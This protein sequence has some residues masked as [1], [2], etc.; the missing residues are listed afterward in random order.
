MGR[1]LGVT[2]EGYL[3]SSAD[4]GETWSTVSLPAGVAGAP[5]SY[6]GFVGLDYNNPQTI[7]L[8]RSLRACGGAPMGAPPGRVGISIPSGRWR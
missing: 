7:Y 4:R 6:R 8:E 5:L 3:M 1:L 2:N